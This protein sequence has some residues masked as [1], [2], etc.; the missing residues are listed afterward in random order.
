PHRAPFLRAS[1]ML[2][3]PPPACVSIGDR[4]EVDIEPPLEL[5]MGGVLVD[6]VEDV[7]GLPRFLGPRGNRVPGTKH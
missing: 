2:G 4:Y 5:G 7:Y 1:E 3:F 6:G